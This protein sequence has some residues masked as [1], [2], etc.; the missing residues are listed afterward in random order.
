MIKP[1]LH[2]T[3]K[4]YQGYFMP[5]YKEKYIGDINNIIYRSSWERKFM[6]WCDNTISVKKWSNESIAIKYFNTLDEKYHKYFVDFFVEL[7]NDKKYLIEI[8]PNAQLK[9]PTLKNNTKS[10]KK[11][12][13]FLYEQKQ[14]ITNVAKW[15]AAY[16]FCIQRGWEFKIITEKT[17][18]LK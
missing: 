13:N 16:E 2:K 8:K 6:V 11:I 3:S 7:T 18:N 5:F 9:E 4:Y 1:S 14:Y 17:M 15:N 10:K 12:D